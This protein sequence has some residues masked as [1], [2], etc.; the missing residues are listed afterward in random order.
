MA[1]VSPIGFHLQQKQMEGS[2]VPRS[3]STTLSG[4]RGGGGRDIGEIE[5]LESLEEAGA[6][7]SVSQGG[8]L[9]VGIGEM[10]F[11]AVGKEYKESKSTLIWALQNSSTDTKLVLVH[12]HRPAQMIPMLGGK[13]PASQLTKQQVNAY[14]LQEREKMNTTLHEY[15]LLCAAKVQAKLLVIEMDDIA[16]G[17]LTLIAQ[18]SITKLVMGAASD[19]HY[20][21]RMK[22]PRSKTASTVQREAPAS[23]SIWFVCKGRLI[24]TRPTELDGEKLQTPLASPSSRFI[25]PEPFGKSLS[26]GTQPTVVGETWCRSE[27]GHYDSRGKEIT[28]GLSRVDPIRLSPLSSFSTERTE[29]DG[30]E[31][32]SH[33]SSQSSDHSSCS[34]SEE[35]NCLVSPSVLRYEDSE[36]GSVMLPSLQES[37]EDFQFLYPQDKQEDGTMQDAICNHQQQDFAEAE[38]AKHVAYGESHRRRRAER[39][40]LE[41]VCKAQMAEN[42]YARELKQRKDIE[43]TLARE[44]LEQEKLK[45]QCDEVITELRKVNEQKSVLENQVIDADHVVRDL[46]EKLS[47]AHRLVN[48]LQAEREELQQKHDHAIRE[49]EE[50]QQGKEEVNAATN[51]KHSFSEFTNLELE[52][53]TSEFDNSLKIGEG[54]SG[55]VYRG[56]LSHTTVAIKKLDPQGLQGQ[57][58]FQQEVEVLGRVRH[59][60]LVTLIGTCIESWCLVYEFLP[61]GSLEDR[62]QCK[63]NS[64]PLSW[65]TRVRIA[66]EICSA[67]VFLHSNKPHT[68]VHG[69]LK[70]ANILLDANFVSKLSDFG[71]SRLLVQP[72]NANS[73]YHL[74][75]PKGT[76][77]YMDP[78]FIATG[79]LSPGS[80]IY[81]FG[82]IILRLLTGRSAWGIAKEVREV[83]TRGTWHMILDKSAGDWPLVQTKQLAYIG[84]RCCELNRR[85]R[86]DL[87]NDIWRVLEPMKKA[88]STGRLT[89]CALTSADDSQM[90]PYFMCPIFQ[91]IMRDPHVAADGF[92]YEAEAV[93][94]WFERGNKTSPMTNLQLQHTSLVPNH[95]LRSAIQEW[96]QQQR[97]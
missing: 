63:D 83:L 57:I 32:I 35:A 54:G 80:D 13:F 90:P 16:K 10:V 94:G 76:I 59:P 47:T 49:T 4:G 96:L 86:P 40:A 37:E 61:N 28:V 82:I 20:S 8:S 95:A 58:Q 56:V 72:T 3:F 50:L 42:L 64:P 71:I 23:C 39:V 62:L 18:H 75:E 79:E 97:S 52:Q 12:V 84:L 24:C 29:I 93:R 14:R 44:K 22:S 2:P 66:A 87:V 21:R 67:L 69:D 74:T 70:P 45:C 5:Q 34:A 26:Q 1:V 53:A 77:P 19:R 31:G 27:S 33:R 46:E 15:L 91:E 78:E 25:Q 73:V 7:S 48:S 30:W 11:V 9:S 68:V 81:S 92:T 51:R 89:S 6:S 38:K 43:E 88:A 55:S 41:A 65:Q 36:N 85:N 17:L 60:H